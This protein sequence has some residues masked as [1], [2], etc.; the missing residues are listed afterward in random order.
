MSSTISAT[1]VSETGPCFVISSYCSKSKGNVMIRG[2]SFSRQTSPRSSAFFIIAFIAAVSLFSDL[3]WIICGMAAII[4]CQTRGSVISPRIVCAPAPLFDSTMVNVAIHTI[5][6]DMKAAFSIVHPHA[7]TATR[8]V[9]SIG[10][11]FGSA[12]LATVAQQ[13]M[14]G[15]ASSDLRAVAHSFNVSFWWAIGFTVI[16]AVPALFLT[17]C[18]KPK[19]ETSL[20]ESDLQTDGQQ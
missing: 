15:R 16:A 10:G 7:S 18:E 12:I 13:Q 9:Q 8:I 5:A 4:L 17:V 1:V 6:A 11:A 3:F 14:A 20:R 19:P 2:D